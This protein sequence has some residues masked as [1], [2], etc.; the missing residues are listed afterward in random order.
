MYPAFTV[1]E[2]ASAWSLMAEVVDVAV[3]SVVLSTPLRD[4]TTSTKIV[5][6]V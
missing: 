5:E 2:T 6:L 4:P 1:S 3:R